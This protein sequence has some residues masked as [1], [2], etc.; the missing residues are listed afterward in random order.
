MKRKFSLIKISKKDAE[1][2]KEL[3]VPKLESDVDTSRKLPIGQEA[4]A[5]TT[6]KDVR[7][8][9]FLKKFFALM[10]LAFHNLPEQLSGHI[11]NVDELR[12]VVIMQAGF[13][14]EHISLSG[15]KFWTP[16]SISFDN[17]TEE[18]FSEVYSKC[19]DVVCNFI[20]PGVESE[21]INE[22]IL[23]FM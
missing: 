23:N 3:W 14:E 5:S 7:N 19:L 11:K 13:R 21:D 20:L 10:N 8:Y 22:Q 2:Q 16:E 18:R 9:Q 6:K 12:K 1:A 17:M 4:V 15:K